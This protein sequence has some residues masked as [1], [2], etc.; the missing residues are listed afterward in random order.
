MR[1]YDITLGE[2]YS[3]KKRVNTWGS[4]FGKLIGSLSL[5]KLTRNKNIEYYYEVTIG[6]LF[7]QKV[8]LKTNLLK[9]LHTVFHS[10]YI[11]LHSH[12]QCKRVFSTPSPVLVVRWFFFLMMAILTGVKWYLFVVLICMSPIMSD[13][14]HL[15]MC[16]L[17]SLEKCLFRFFAHFLTRL[18]HFSGVELYELLLYFGN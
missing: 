7:S 15:F 14:E 2:K 4:F 8:S 18:F 12:Q 11:N 13:V 3:E 1:N 10:G 16:L 6:D 9:N 5:L 17:A